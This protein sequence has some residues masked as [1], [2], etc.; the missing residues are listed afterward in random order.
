MI[1]DEGLYD[2]LSE[3]AGLAALVSTRIYPLKAPQDATY[4]LVVYQQI[5]GPRVH[6]HSGGSGLA[7]PR[8]QFTSW[9][10]SLN[11]AKGVANQVRAA[12]NGYNGTMG[13]DVD[14]QACLLQ[15]EMEL[16]DPETE[17]WGVV[18]D[19]VIWHAE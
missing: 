18:Q 4:P 9:A 12:L 14:V 19:F 6:S 8:F 11:S 16:Y 17:R 5:S 7:S 13:S 10:T 3:Y 2:T 1:I 15:N